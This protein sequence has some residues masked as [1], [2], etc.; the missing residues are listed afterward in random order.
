MAL[1]DI[2]R[3]NKLIGTTVDI[4]ILIPIYIPEKLTDRINSISFS[5]GAFRPVLWKP[6]RGYW[7]PTYSIDFTFKI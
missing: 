4:A 5:I 7:H 2:D 6:E 1:R 3:N